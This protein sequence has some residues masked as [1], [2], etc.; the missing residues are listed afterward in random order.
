MPDIKFEIK[1]K[2]RC[3]FCHPE[4]CPCPDY[5]LYVNDEYWMNGNRDYLE[6]MIEKIEQLIDTISNLQ[7]G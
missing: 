3:Q 7:K 6:S 1:D 2:P 5:E 4:T